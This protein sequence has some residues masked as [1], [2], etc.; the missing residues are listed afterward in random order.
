MQ[1]IGAGTRTPVVTLALLWFCASGAHA[2]AVRWE[3]DRERTQIGFTV[4]QG[5][6]GTIRGEFK[7]SSARVKAHPETGHITSLEGLVWSMSV[8]TNMNT[9]DAYLREDVFESEKH[10]IFRMKTKSIR[11]NGSQFTGVATMTIKDVTRDVP[12][13]GKLRELRVVDR[14]GIKTRRATYE[15]SA[16][17]SRKMFGLTFGSLLERLSLVNDEVTIVLDVETTHRVR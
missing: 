12:F 16:K 7:L 13:W 17:I 2:E 6:M 11:W 10:P 5:G 8:A 14:G 15:A 3:L 4:V 9:L 1:V